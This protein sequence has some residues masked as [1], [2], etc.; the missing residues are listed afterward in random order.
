M[1][2]VQE[3][4]P[5]AKRRRKTVENPARK[6]DARRTAHRRDRL[7]SALNIS[8][9]SA[10]LL[11]LP[12][13]LQAGSVFFL[14]LV[15]GLTFG[16]MLA[17]LQE[18]LER[19][20]H[21]TVAA[22]LNLGLLLLFIGVISYIIVMPA[23]AWLNELPGRLPNVRENI[24]PIIDMFDTVDESVD[25]LSEGLGVEGAAR[26]APPADMI[27]APASVVDAIATAAPGALL[28]TF[29][30][31][32]IIV[33]FL[34]TY[35]RIRRS[36]VAGARTRAG[37]VTAHQLLSDVAS[38]TGRYVGTITVIN[39]ILGVSVTL[40]F[41]ALGVETPYMWGGLAGLLNFVPYVGPVVFFFLAALGGMATQPDWISGMVPAAVYL[42][43]NIMEAYILTPAILGR[44][45]LINP[46]LI[47]IALSF[48]GWVWGA[49]GA[50]LS[51]PLL[52]ITRS[53]VARVGGPNFVGF[54]LD[55]T[56]LMR[57]NL[58]LSGTARPERPAADDRPPH[59]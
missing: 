9:A 16:L 2:E 59:P 3:S 37:A 43:I 42:A 33:F 19:L 30:A 38:D 51:V 56:T 45:F 40:A 1:T 15:T 26:E 22:V 52:I 23:L 41:W 12:F 20:L 49:M 18:R 32:L 36:L 57:E 17:P 21:P 58:A 48:W 47:M 24:A 13:A 34:A 55:Q 28:Q 53:L 11:A 29:F 31:L 25:R 54:L 44:R 10:L 35:T 5:R 6:T 14:P 27:G 46:L 39:I 50:L 7:L 4:G 8:M